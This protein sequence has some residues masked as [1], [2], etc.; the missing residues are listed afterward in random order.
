MDL[1]GCD[2]CGRDVSPRAAFC[3]GCGAV[4]ASSPLRVSAVDVDI[5]FGN[6]V[7]LMLK[8]AIGAIPAAIILFTLGAMAWAVLTGALHKWGIGHGPPRRSFF[9]AVVFGL[10]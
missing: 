1:V 2:D 4:R 10:A 3:P 7:G 6:V 5:G 8:I 9:F